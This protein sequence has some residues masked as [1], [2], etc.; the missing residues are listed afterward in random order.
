MTTKLIFVR[1]CEAASNIDRFFRGQTEA[2]IS[3]KGRRQ[4]ELLSARFRDIHY[5]YIYSSP[6]SRTMQTAQAVNRTLNLPIIRCEG[7]MEINGGDWEGRPWGE[8]PSVYPEQSEK[9]ANAP[10]EFVA[11]GGESMVQARERITRAAVEIAE[12]HKGKT[13]VCVSHG[14]AI[15][16]LTCWALGYPIERLND[17]EWAENTSINAF[18]FDEA[19]RPRVIKANDSAHLDAQMKTL[20]RQNWWKK[21]LSLEEKF[22]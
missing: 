10:H 13:V 7:I 5:D 21:E 11:P 2:Q 18:E 1:H 8:L 12:R 16:N 17:I 9:W 15:R 20:A 6:L 3:E 22:K 4:L 19:M 14:C